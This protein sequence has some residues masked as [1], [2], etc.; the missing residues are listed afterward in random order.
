MNEA[1]PNDNISQIQIN[2]PTHKMSFLSHE[3]NRNNSHILPSQDQ[4]RLRK[5]QSLRE[6]TEKK[7]RGQPRHAGTTLECSSTLDKTIK[8]NP[9]QCSSCGSNFY[10]YPEQLVSTKAFNRYTHHRFKMY[11]TSGILKSIQLRA[12]NH[13]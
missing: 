11:R 9:E 6:P 4:N 1:K 13:Q 12:Y 2:Y 7:V 3:K 5:N 8:N 10:S